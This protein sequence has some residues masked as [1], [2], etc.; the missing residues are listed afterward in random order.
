MKSQ[1]GS[2][3][4]MS[5]LPDAPCSS[6]LLSLGVL[7]VGDVPTQMPEIL[8]PGPSRLVLRLLLGVLTG[9]SGTHPHER[10]TA[11]H[12][13]APSVSCKLRE[14]SQGLKRDLLA[15]SLLH[16]ESTTPCDPSTLGQAWTSELVGLHDKVTACSGPEVRGKLLM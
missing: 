8:T 2:Q 14:L 15:D 12:R 7:W 4:Q 1:A 9:L 11:E 10:L 3:D 16:G 13:T 5:R 6:A